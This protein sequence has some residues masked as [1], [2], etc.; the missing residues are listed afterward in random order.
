MAGVYVDSSALVKLIVREA[1]SDAIRNYLRR[2]RPWVS[3]ALA[4]TEVVRAVAGL[5]DPAIAAA[6]QV[7][8][9]C[10]LVRLNDRLLDRAGLLE[11]A[12]VRSLDAVHLATAD[13]VRADLGALVTYDERMAEAA[14]ALGLRVAAPA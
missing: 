14:R 10:D 12:E 4:R 7:L 6:R 13:L 5:G 2:R 3:S 8:A 9:R 1:E 11:P